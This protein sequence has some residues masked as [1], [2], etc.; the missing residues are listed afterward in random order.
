VPATNALEVNGNASKS[1]AGD[2]LANSDARIKKDIA[3]VSNAL[4]VI[5]RL[6]P[7]Q[8]RYKDE[9]RAEHPFIKNVPYFNY[10]AQDFQQVFPDSVQDSGEDGILQIDTH[11]A[12][13]YAVAAIKELHAKVKKRDAEISDLKERL[14]VLERKIASR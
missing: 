12:S 1:T 7:V 3:P 13:I 8:F 4:D 10:I 2:W 6:R 9:Y 14:A 5:D 11:P